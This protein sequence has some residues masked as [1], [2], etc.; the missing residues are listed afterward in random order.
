MAV[1][2]TARASVRSKSGFVR[3]FIGPGLRQRPT[4]GVRRCEKIA[5][6]TN[7]H[8]NSL[9]KRREIFRKIN[10]FT[11]SQRCRV[12]GVQYETK[13]RIRHPLYS[14]CYVSSQFDVDY[15][16]ETPPKYRTQ[17]RWLNIEN[18]P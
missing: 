12:V 17:R 3:F 7:H 9:G 18:S 4:T 2:A 1:T 14:A 13:W 15:L 10:F 16:T 5:K 6:S 11:A 8:A